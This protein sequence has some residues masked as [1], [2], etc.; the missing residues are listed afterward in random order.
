[1]WQTMTEFFVSAFYYPGITPGGL[2]AGVLL[3]LAFG[4]VWMSAYIAP[5][6][7]KR[8]LWAVMLASAVLCWSAIS[9]IQIPLQLLIGELLGGLWT[10]DVL[11]KNILIAGI[12]Q[13]L[14]S[15]L[16]QE[17]AKIV[18]VV[19][20]WWYAGKQLEL[21][22]GLLYGAAAGAG[23]G[24]FEA[25]WA[26][27]MVFAQG[28]TWQAVEVNGVIAFTPFWERFF[29]VALH[30]SLTA[31][32][33]Y[34]LAKGRG[35]LYYLIAAV[36]HSLANYS[37]IL[38]KS[39]LFNVLQLEIYTALITIATTAFVLWLRWNKLGSEGP[40]VKVNCKK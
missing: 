21:K 2:V 29:V 39:G 6:F 12:P 30:V 20:W 31:L 35:W 8:W 17:G 26:H 3:G 10:A 33:G 27:N 16:V 13:I 36:L 40:Q 37:V 7:E 32:V 1:M 22:Q 18:P 5:L 28:W 11:Q 9:F 34:G 19:A 15:G 14:C 38:L 4:A 24:V 23:F 25:I